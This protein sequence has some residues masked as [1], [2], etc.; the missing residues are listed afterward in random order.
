MLTT[1]ILPPLW[2]RQ[3]IIAVVAICFVTSQPSVAQE[4]RYELGKRLRRFEEAW[5]Q[6][7]DPIRKQSAPILQQAVSSFFSLNLLGAAEKLDQA[8]VVTRSQPTA[9]WERSAIPYRIQASAILIDEATPSITVRLTPF[10]NKNEKA[11]EGAKVQWSVTDQSLRV[12]AERECMLEEAMEGIALA[13]ENFPEGDYWLR[14]KLIL[15][16][17]TF[18][19]P[20]RCSVAFR[21]GTRG[22]RR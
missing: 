2:F 10:Y 4:E 13:T 18:V 16:E 6:A 14:A 21:N 22:R 20:L 15:E 9:S 11:P 17:G 7:P 3:A 12:M 8:W 1:P 19:F 5:Q